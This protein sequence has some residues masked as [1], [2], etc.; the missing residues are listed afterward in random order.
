MDQAHAGPADPAMLVRD[1]VLAHWLSLLQAAQ[2]TCGVGC[3]V[4]VLT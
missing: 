4:G 3:G 2:R 1:Y